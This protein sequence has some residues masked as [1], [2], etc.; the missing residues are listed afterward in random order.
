VSEDSEGG[1]GFFCLVV[2][3]RVITA[4]VKGHTS[5]E[6]DHSSSQASGTLLI[7]RLVV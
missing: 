6:L 4:D 2:N 1:V 3:I 7:A 5:A